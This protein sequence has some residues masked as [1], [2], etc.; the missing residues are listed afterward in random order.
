MPTENRSSNT[1]QMVSVPRELVENVALGLERIGSGR[2]WVD[3]LRALLAQPAA[4]HQGE[5]VTLPACKAKLS[6]SHDWDQGYAAG[7][8]ACLD[9]IAKLGP[10]YTHAD[11][12][13]VERLRELEEM[14]RTSIFNKSAE[15]QKLKTDCKRLLAKLAERD[16]LLHRWVGNFGHLGGCATPLRDETK[17]A[18]SANAEPAPTSDG[19]SAG[20]MADQGAKAFAA[21]DGEV[22]RLRA[23]LKFY[24]D[25]DH[26]SED[27]RSDWDSVSGEP[28]NVLWH[29]SE[30]WFVEDGSIARAALEAK[31]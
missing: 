16:A 30:A 31:P 8:S 15:I 23:A 5:P 21:R 9:E 10:L 27:M 29:E 11:P 26:F 13:E 17:A 4:Q 22:E 19:F 28:A 24:A 6:M 2:N 3:E 20:D 7:W 25:R 14:L 18:L 12:A 1:E